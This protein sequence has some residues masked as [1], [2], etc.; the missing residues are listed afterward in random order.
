MCSGIKIQG[1]F[2]LAELPTSLSPFVLSENGVSVSL[3]SV[4]E[5][6]RAFGLV[7]KARL[8]TPASHS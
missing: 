4:T 7:I 5:E 2:P 8:G 3:V 6:M 1:Y